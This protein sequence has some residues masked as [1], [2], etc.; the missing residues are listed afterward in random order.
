MPTSEFWRTQNG[1][2]AWLCRNCMTKPDFSI[3]KARLKLFLDVDSKHEGAITTYAG[4]V[5]HFLMR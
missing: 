5:T 4:L 1:A 2:A 3:I